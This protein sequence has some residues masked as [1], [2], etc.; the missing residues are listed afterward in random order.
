V[1]EELGSRRGLA[2]MT[3]QQKLIRVAL[4]LRLPPLPCTSMPIFSFFF[5]F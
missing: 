3:E 5:F 2:Y 4:V 1:L